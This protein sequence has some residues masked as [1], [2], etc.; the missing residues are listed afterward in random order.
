MLRLFKSAHSL[1]VSKGISTIYEMHVLFQSS[2]GMS[3]VFRFVP[4]GQVFLPDM[5]QNKIIS[6]FIDMLKE[7][8]IKKL[9]EDCERYGITD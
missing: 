2:E 9:L 4:A 3:K 1:A 7:S 6:F 5:D 8:Q